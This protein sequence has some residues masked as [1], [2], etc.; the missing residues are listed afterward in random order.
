VDYTFYSL[1]LWRFAPNDL[2]A[3]GGYD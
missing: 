3:L 2:R 1:H